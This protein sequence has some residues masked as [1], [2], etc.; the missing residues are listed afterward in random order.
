[1]TAKP[2][3]GDAH[4]SG[5]PLVLIAEDEALIAMELV[6]GLRHAGFEV[7]GPFARCAEAEEWLQTGSPD[8]AVVDSLLKDGPCDA[9]VADLSCRGIPT[10][11]FSGRDEPGVRASVDRHARWVPKPSA[12]PMLL[13][14]LRQEMGAA[15]M[16]GNARHR[17]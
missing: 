11:I 10:L 8:A 17:R 9:L 12:F 13:D 5:R 14:A 2:H 6:D 7:A 16:T 4:D 1:M 3:G 15:G